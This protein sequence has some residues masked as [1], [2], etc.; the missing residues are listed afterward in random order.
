[1]LRRA[2]RHNCGRQVWQRACQGQLQQFRPFGHPVVSQSSWCN[3]V[4]RWRYTAILPGIPRAWSLDLARGA[5]SPRCVFLG[6][7]L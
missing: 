6:L 5:L 7:L 2:S 4:V 3:L 1:M